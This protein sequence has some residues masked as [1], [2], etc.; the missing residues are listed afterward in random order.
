MRGQLACRVEFA[1]LAFGS[2]G[3]AK[4][5]S[6]YRLDA[7]RIAAG[8]QGSLR[9]GKTMLA[10]DQIVE[11]DSPRGGES[12]CGRPCIGITECAGNEQLPLL[13]HAKRQLQFI[14]THPNEH[15]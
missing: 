1:L 8:G 6:N 4:R 14:C 15:D 10:S 9:V 2:M 7:V 3:I 11:T 13:D 12:D 5:G